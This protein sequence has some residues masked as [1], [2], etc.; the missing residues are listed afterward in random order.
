[1]YLLN[2][3]DIYIFNNRDVI[4]RLMNAYFLYTTYIGHHTKRS[5]NLFEKNAFIFQKEHWTGKHAQR[6]FRV[7][8]KMHMYQKWSNQFCTTYYYCISLTLYSCTIN[9]CNVYRLRIRQPCLYS[10][11]VNISLYIFTHTYLFNNIF[12]QWKFLK[13]LY[14]GVPMKNVTFSIFANLTKYVSGNFYVFNVE[15]MSKHLKV[16]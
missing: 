9:V 14:Q 10:G 13:I 12:S 11:R 7:S 3:C 1:M 8:I 6:H 16:H 4:E 15:L 5:K 2:W